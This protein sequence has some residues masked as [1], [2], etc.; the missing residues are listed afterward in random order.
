MLRRFILVLLLLCL[1]LRLWAGM[2]LMAS[3]VSDRALLVVLTQSVQHDQADHPC[4][5]E[6]TS[7]STDAVETSNDPCA[8]GDCRICSACHMPALHNLNLLDFS[9]DSPRE[10]L[11]VASSLDYSAPQTALFKPPVS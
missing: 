8:G 10:W 1:P 6:L 9:Q 11:L 3:E 5:E 2:G 4:H 7:L